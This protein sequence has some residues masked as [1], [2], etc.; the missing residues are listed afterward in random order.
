MAGAYDHKLGIPFAVTVAEQKVRDAH[1]HSVELERAHRLQ[2]PDLVDERRLQRVNEML[3][4]CSRVHEVAMHSCRRRLYVEHDVPIDL[5]ALHEAAAE[6]LRCR[7]DAAV[8]ERLGVCS[9][10]VM[11][12]VGR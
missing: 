12:L 2:R 3:Q 9:Q 6:L 10:I 11:E 1:H 7:T 8:R 5:L 4:N